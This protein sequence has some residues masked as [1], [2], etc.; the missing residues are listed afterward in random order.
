MAL[1]AAAPRLEGSP[2]VQVV[3]A[4]GQERW[5]EAEARI[6]HELFAAG[7]DEAP[8]S[9]AIGIRIELR[10]ELRL[11]QGEGRA[12]VTLV[13]ATEQVV[14]ARELR[15][16]A[17]D[18]QVRTLALRALEAVRAL[19]LLASTN[20]AQS[21][22]ASSPPAPATTTG[23][24]DAAWSVGITT[25]LLGARHLA[26][27]PALGAR[28]VWLA[29]SGREVV[30]QAS[31]TPL[32]S[33]VASGGESARLWTAST[34]ALLGLA[35]SRAPWS[36]GVR[37]GAG[38]VV[39]YGRGDSSPRVVGAT[40]TLV[41]AELRAE[42]WAGVLLP[43]GLRVCVEAALPMPLDRLRVVSG[44]QTLVD[45]VPPWWQAGFGLQR[46]WP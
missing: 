38:A 9:A 24:T 39:V 6:R 8:A 40:M 45:L 44:T 11:E 33:K 12:I 4:E 17:G 41:A 23:A 2:T 28:L 21:A 29:E 3:A 42:V 15:A 20:A 35:A 25:G 16:E 30:L 10:L 7:Y 14:E 43:G 26:A 1:V 13:D 18:S 36:A 46:S 34:E 19:S 32:A 22:A 31:G 37:A 5:P 27:S